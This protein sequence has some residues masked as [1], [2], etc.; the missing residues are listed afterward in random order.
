MEGYA[1]RTLLAGAAA[2]MAMAASG[3]FAPVWAASP[4]PPADAAFLQLSRLLTGRANLDPETGR[5]LNA[6]LSAARP[7]FGA[8]VS[9]CAGFARAHG[10]TKVEP[11]AAALRQQNP[12]LAEVLHAIVSA[13]YVGVAGDGPGGEVVAYREALMF[14]TVGDVLTAPSYCRAA[15]GEWTSK[16]P[17]ADPPR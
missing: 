13:W 1:R 11:L 6:V 15:P 7:G 16:P 5:R 17:R 14:A 2:G 4:E 9:A 10:M 12:K 8:Q 3:G